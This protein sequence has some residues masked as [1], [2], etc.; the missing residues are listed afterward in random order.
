MRAR[1]EQLSNQNSK[2]S[3]LIYEVNVPVFE[4]YWHYHPEYELTFIIKGK[5]KRLVG[6]NYEHFEAGDLV[7][8]GPML[9]HTWVG[10]KQKNENCTAIVIQFSAAFIKPLLQYTEFGVIESL[11]ARAERGLRFTATPKN[12]TTELIQKMACY[13]GIDLFTALLQVLY[14]LAITKSVP[15]STVR[16][17]PVKGDEN[18]QRINKIFQYVQ[19]HFREDLSLQK[20][21]MLIHLSQSA[22]CKFFKRAI[23]KTFSEYV[24]DIRI[25][26]ACQLLIETDKQVSQIATESGFESLT[27]FN[28]VFLKKKGIRPGEFRK[29]IL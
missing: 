9:P 12:K 21:A 1:L 6:D 2:Q 26:N 13:K 23:G 5:G 14:K 22:F 18:N 19:K 20:A 24:N 15:L 3:F 4:F 29:N 10:E 8:L 16:Y 11:L 27:Y 28:R 7:L 17:K 25:A